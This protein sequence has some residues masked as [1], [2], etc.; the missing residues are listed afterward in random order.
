MGLEAAGHVE[1]GSLRGHRGLRTARADV[2]EHGDDVHR[3]EAIRGLDT[4]EVGLRRRDRGPDGGGRLEIGGVLLELH[5]ELHASPDI[6]PGEEHVDGGVDAVLGGGL[7]DVGGHR[8][9]ENF[10]ILVD[11]GEVEIDVARLP[12]LGDV[13]EDPNQGGAVVGE[14][15][16]APLGTHPGVPLGDG[17]L[18]ALV[19]VDLPDRDASSGRSFGHGGAVLG[20]ALGRVARLSRRGVIASRLVDGVSLGTAGDDQQR[21]QAQKQRCA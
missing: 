17:D 2:V 12:V 16:G 9:R 4:D 6:L 8:V 18:D 1:D 19:G 13:V 10:A 3:D 21:G 5:L 11:D 14:D 20:A 15:G 7:G